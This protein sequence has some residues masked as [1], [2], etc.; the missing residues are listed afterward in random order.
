[1]DF[2]G[3]QIAVNPEVYVLSHL[4]PSR[5]SEME[6]T[7][8]ELLEPGELAAIRFYMVFH[9]LCSFAEFSITLEMKSVF[10]WTSRLDHNLL[11][12]NHCISCSLQIGRRPLL[13]GWRPSLLG[14]RLSLLFGQE[15]RDTCSLDIGLRPQRKK[16]QN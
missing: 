5:K 1:M 16:T 14:W 2:R 8:E 15:H 11:V 7:Q 6:K 4:W 10:C 9:M 13:V 3:Q 12:M